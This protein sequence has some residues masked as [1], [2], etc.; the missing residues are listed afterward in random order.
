MKYLKS[1]AFL[2]LGVFVFTVNAQSDCEANWEDGWCWGADPDKAK[3]K[4]ALYT[5][6]FKLENFQEAA[7]DLR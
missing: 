6:A 1:A 2:F 5:D 7:T 3:E 4:N